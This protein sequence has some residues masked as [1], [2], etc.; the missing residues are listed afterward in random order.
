MRFVKCISPALYAMPA[1]DLY[2]LQLMNLLQ[3][4]GR[5]PNAELARRVGM[6]PS[7]VLERVRKLEEREVIKGYEARMD[8]KQ[9]GL[10]LTAFIFVRANASEVGAKLVEL[11][12]I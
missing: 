3:E 9:I 2:D 8:P 11:P 7:A 12:E 1:F 10:G 6:A 5:M 4:D